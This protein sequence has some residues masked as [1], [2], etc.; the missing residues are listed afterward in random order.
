MYFDVFLFFYICP[1]LKRMICWANLCELVHLKIASSSYSLALCSYYIHDFVFRYICLLSFRPLPLT[2][3]SNFFHR[4]TVEL[5]T[6]PNISRKAIQ[7]IVNHT[8][9]M[10]KSLSDLLVS[11]MESFV[12]SLSTCVSPMPVELDHAVSKHTSKTFNT[13]FQLLLE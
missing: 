12:K 13:L 6:K 1:W 3:Q 5:Y 7:E 11:G 8:D 10:L 4:F 2:R 9:N